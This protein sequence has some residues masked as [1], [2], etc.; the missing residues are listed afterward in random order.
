MPLLLQF[1]LWPVAIYIYL[2][3]YF[4][5]LFYLHDEDINK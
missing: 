5:P 3:Y 2:H 1:D 4:C